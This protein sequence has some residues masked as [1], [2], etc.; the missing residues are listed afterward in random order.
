MERMTCRLLRSTSST[1]MPSTMSLIWKCC[2]VSAGRS[3][4]PSAAA[5]M[6][7]RTPREVLLTTMPSASS[8]LRMSSR[9]TGASSGAGAGE[10]FLGGGL[11]PALE[12]ARGAGARPRWASSKAR[13]RRWRSRSSLVMRMPWTCSPESIRTWT[14]F[15]TRSLPSLTAP[16]FTKTPYGP[17][18]QMMPS[19][20]MPS[21]SSS[22][23]TRSCCKLSSV[24]SR[25]TTARPTRSR[26]R[27]T[28][29][30]RRSRSWSPTLNSRLNL[31]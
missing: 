31:A 16:M 19:T 5:P 7:T 9:G 22:N 29:C 4:V 11:A 21:S 15:G 28:R 20:I 10:A 12:P 3:R 2:L 27:S 23:G 24:A 14:C 30:T 18:P 25:S 17:A 1:T 13:D 6:S 8:P 26:R